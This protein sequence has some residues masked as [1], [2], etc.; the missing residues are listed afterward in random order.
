[1]NSEVFLLLFCSSHRQLDDA[2]IC[3]PVTHVHCVC[4]T[5]RSRA[6]KARGNCSFRSGNRPD[7]ESE[8][9][10]THI[11]TNTAVLSTASPLSFP[12][13]IRHWRQS[14]LPST[15]FVCLRQLDDSASTHT[16]DLSLNFSIVR[17]W[18]HHRHHHHQSSAVHR[19][20]IVSFLPPFHCDAINYQIT[21][22]DASLCNLLVNSVSL[23]LSSFF[24]NCPHLFFVCQR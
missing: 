9:A 23:S 15:V 5:C 19:L 12:L 2:D 21:V 24:L 8:K 16:H 18:R 13:F 11:Y 20:S 22:C 7:R 4:F 17:G 6:V 10:Y 1:M 3:T 14:T